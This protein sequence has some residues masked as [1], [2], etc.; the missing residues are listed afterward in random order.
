MKT[1]FTIIAAIACGPLSDDG[2]RSPCR[3]ASVPATDPHANR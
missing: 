2:N 3:L 1:F